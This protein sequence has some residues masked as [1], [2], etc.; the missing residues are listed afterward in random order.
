LV[1][2]LAFRKKCGKNN[3]TRR[4]PGGNQEETRRKPGGNLFSY[5]Y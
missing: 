2:V 3:R 4:K 5:I 1:L